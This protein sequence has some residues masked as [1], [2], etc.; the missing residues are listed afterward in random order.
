RPR[1]QKFD[2]DGNFILQWFYGDDNG[3]TDYA[4]GL[5]IDRFDHVYLTSGLENSVL[6]FNA[7]GGLLYKFGSS[8]NGDGQFDRPYALSVNSAGIAYT[9]DYNNSRILA[10][11]DASPS[12]PSGVYVNPASSTSVSLS[13]TNP[14]DMDFAHV[15]I[16]RST[17]TFPISVTDGSL[18]A[19]SSGT[20]LTDSGRTNGETYY[21]GFFGIDT[22]GNASSVVT[23]AV[24]VG[25]PPNP[26]T[27]VSASQSGATVLLG[28]TNPAGGDFSS[29]TIRYSSSAFPQHPISG[30]AVTTNYTGNSLS[31]SGVSTGTY[32]YS[33]FAK[34]SGGVYSVAATA[35]V[36]VDLT[37][38]NPPQG[39][40]V[41]KLGSTAQLS[42]S[43]PVDA[44]FNSIM[45]RRST[46]AYPT[47]N[48]SGVLVTQNIVGT[49]YSDLLSV[50]GTYYYG[51]F[52][53]DNSGNFSNGV[54][55]SVVVD[56]T[57]PAKP[58]SVSASVTASTIALSWANPADADF[59][60]ITI[61]R[62]TSDY[63]TDISSGDLVTQNFTGTTL[64]QT[65]LADGTYYYS[66]F[67]RDVVGNFGSAA[68]VNAVVDT[69][70]PAK[71]SSVSA[72]ATGSTI[73]L[74]WTNPA[75][76]DF[77]SI[78]I[79][80]ST[81]GY[82]ANEASGDLVTQNF[83]GTTLNQTSLADGTYYYS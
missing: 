28:W 83:T 33:V 10:F 66:V 77:S 40:T 73:A 41:T 63:P 3:G 80:R 22:L 69:T 61:R 54:T 43:N 37:G 6:V 4:H 39:V 53:Q 59:S 78:T 72:S 45:I 58:S 81:V 7:D 79:R 13:W 26:V 38:P 46:S 2:S 65:S 19:T 1:V 75:D 25:T 15:M 8:G 49:S 36:T 70:A 67:A 60:A 11:K 14:L 74:S 52:A 51:L 44:D 31:V 5:A 34:N 27:G 82:P 24:T 64:N 76:A 57:A 56:T 55:G 9:V 17:T 32:Y 12:P 16:R 20:L 18:V 35:S 48:S 50:D 42:W 62:S 21:Y 71:P 23:A 47:T 30:S 68:T 29:V